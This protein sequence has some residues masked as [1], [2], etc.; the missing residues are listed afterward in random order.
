M[1]I[2]AP[3]FGLGFAM[4]VIGALLLFVSFRS[5]EDDERGV[6]YRSAGIIFI[7]PIPIVL[8]GRG[9]WML[10]GIAAAVVIVFLVVLAMAQPGSF[11]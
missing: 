9:K 4:T 2:S 10:I 1:G 8:G 5:R 11:G 6:E 7:G 3:L